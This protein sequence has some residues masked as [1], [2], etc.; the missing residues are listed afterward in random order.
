MKWISII[1]LDSYLFVV[2][3]AIWIEFNICKLDEFRNK[4]KFSNDNPPIDLIDLLTKYIYS[5]K[6]ENKRKI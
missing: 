4:I 5:F 1:R 6:V 2:D 3:F